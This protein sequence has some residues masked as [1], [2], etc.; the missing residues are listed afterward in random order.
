MKVIKGFERLVPKYYS[1]LYDVLK[2]IVA[3]QENQADN[4]TYSLLG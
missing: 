2:A 4:M 3:V 1:D